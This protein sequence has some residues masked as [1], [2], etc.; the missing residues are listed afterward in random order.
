MEKLNSRKTYSKF[1]Y[2]DI[3]QLGIIVEEEYLFRDDVPSVEPSDF[4]QLVLKKNMD[5]KLKTEKAKSELLITPI[6]NEL[7]EQN[8]ERVAYY[9]GYKFEVDKKLGLNGFCDYI[10]TFNPKSPIIDAP[11]FCV[12]EAKNDNLDTGV[13]QCIAE[14]YAAQLFNRKKGKNIENIYG[15]VTFGF[16]WR[17]LKLTENNVIL[18]KNIYYLVKLPELLGVLNEILK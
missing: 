13:P 15:T 3:Q 14:M 16:E 6:L 4:L 18:D 9:S 8:V 10:L 5:K 7:I 17:F 1:T 12:V 11:V 2:D